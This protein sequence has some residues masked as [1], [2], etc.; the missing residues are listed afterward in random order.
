MVDLK[1]KHRL[2]EIDGVP[3]NL[4][5]AIGETFSLEVMNPDGKAYS[6]FMDND[7][8]LADTGLMGNPDSTSKQFTATAVGES[9]I[10]IQYTENGKNVPTIAR[11]YKVSVVS[12]EAVDAALRSRG[13]ERLGAE[14]A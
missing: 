7:P 6:W 14:Q 9:T 11:A 4:R 2:I 8:V 12:S 13:S 10:Q 1:L 5:I 3:D